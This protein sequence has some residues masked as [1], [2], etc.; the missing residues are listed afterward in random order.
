[1]KSTTDTTN[2]TECQANDPTRQVGFRAMAD[3]TP[4]EFA[5][6]DA[7]EL[8]R[9]RGTADR[10]LTALRGIAE[11][12]T[13]YR[14]DRLTHSLQSATLAARNGEDEDYVVC[15]L[16]HDIGDD[17][18]P[19]NHGAFAAEIVKPFVTRELWW[20][21]RHHG[22]FQG[23]WFWHHLGLDRHTRDKHR[24]HPCFD[25]TAR[26]CELYDQCAFDADY[27]TLPLSEFEPMVQRVFDRTPWSLWEGER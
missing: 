22:T 18:A 1:M 27:D 10:V 16:L 13:G 7:L 6:I 5:L 26:F 24:D 3:G 9:A 2:D 23:Y 8:R 25:M 20:M 14:V 17:L 4:E 11:D 21:V 19:H 15:A 12:P